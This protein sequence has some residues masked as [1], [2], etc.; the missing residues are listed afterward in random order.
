MRSKVIAY[1]LAVLSSVFFGLTFLGAKIALTE[2]DPIQVLAC[3][4]TVCLVLYLVLIAVGV[5][6]VK[7]KGKAIKWL[8]LLALMQPCVSQIFE[9]VGIDMITA[10]ESAIMYAMIPMIVTL[11]SIIF[12]K[13]ITVKS[14]IP[15]LKKLVFNLYVFV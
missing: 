6:K 8:L 14:I 7:L 3:R 5:I 4:W 9:T 2:L 11:I 10:S 13:I 15:M 1:I 12:L